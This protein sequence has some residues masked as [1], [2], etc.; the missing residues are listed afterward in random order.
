[1]EDDDTLTINSFS[2]NATVDNNPGPG[3]TI[4]TY[5]YQPA[6]RAIEK[7][8][9]KIAIGFRI[10][11]PSPTQILRFLMKIDRGGLGWNR[12][13]PSMVISR[14]SNEEPTAV[15][16]VLSLVQQSQ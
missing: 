13:G 14:M 12:D 11:Q 3:R 2:T 5:F 7:L 1:M 10:W 15:P 16:G 8:A 4:D 9:L 6:G